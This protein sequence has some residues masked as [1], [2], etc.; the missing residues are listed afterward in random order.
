M[1]K[2]RFK[3][4]S[5]IAVASMGL[6]SCAGSS[7]GGSE[8]G[9]LPSGTIQIVVPFGA[10]GSLDTSARV[11]AECLTANTDN[12][13]IVENREGGGGVTGV[14]YVLDSE[15]NGATVGYVSSSGMTLTPLQVD[16]AEYTLD[17]IAPLASI[18]GAPSVIITAP[19]SGNE[20]LND[21]LNSPD[22]E[23]TLAT[24]G[25]LG[26]YQ[27][28]AE[29]L[30]SDAS[31]RPVPFGGAAEA[32]TAAL[33]NNVDAAILEL[34]DSI[35]EHVESDRLKILG[36]GAEEELSYLPDTP[37]ISDAGF[38][39]PQST[40]YGVFIGNPDI[41]DETQEALEAEFL[42]CAAD[43]TVIETIGEQFVLEAPYGREETR[44]LLE[45]MRQEFESELK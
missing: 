45:E 26:I 2:P 35:L 22:S 5:F 37:T 13:W 17:D 43:E 4:I 24:T 27:L 18:T 14:N 25:S 32:T 7:A 16:N 12:K 30:S 41:S 40:N 36:T 29:T 42:A 15:P 11:M 20:D 23:K 19:D 28:V 31:V 38:E 8:S 34:H 6:A 39:V 3:V 21:L 10:G 33:G 44:N 9:A 1:K